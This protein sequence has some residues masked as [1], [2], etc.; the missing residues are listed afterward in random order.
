M[1]LM[2][3]VQFLIRFF[4]GALSF[5]FGLI[6][7]YG[8]QFTPTSV[9]ISEVKVLNSPDLVFLFFGNSGMYIWT[10]GLAQVIGGLL[11]IYKKTSLFGAFICITIFTNI[12]L[13]NI[14]FNFSLVLQ[15]LICFADLCCIATLWLHRQ[16]IRDLLV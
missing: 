14:S 12:L 15:L 7:L 13:I 2:K 9:D 5:F 3:I 8:G 1:T 4:P 6:K 16:K 11:L 10:I